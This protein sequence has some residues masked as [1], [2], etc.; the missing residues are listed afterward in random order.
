MAAKTEKMQFWIVAHPKCSY[1]GKVPKL[2]F[3]NFTKKI[4][5]FWG[6]FVEK[7]PKN[8]VFNRECLENNDFF[9]WKN[10]ENQKRIK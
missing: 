2:I 3:E 8:S 7:V 6:L 9:I 5:I 10:H 1:V 4:I